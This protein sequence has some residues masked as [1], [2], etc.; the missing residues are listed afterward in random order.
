MENIMY[1]RPVLYFNFIPDYQYNKTNKYNVYEKPLK[2]YSFA[3][4]WS[5]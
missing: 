2:K 3:K 5:K 4:Y 1:L